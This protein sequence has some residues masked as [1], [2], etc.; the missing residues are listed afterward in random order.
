MTEL[1]F[2]DNTINSRIG[3]QHQNRRHPDFNLKLKDEGNFTVAFK[4]D[5][6]YIYIYI[7]F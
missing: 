5:N 1:I 7:F 2:W 3:R 4:E 6:I